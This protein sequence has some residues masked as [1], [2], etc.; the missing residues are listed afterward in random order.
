M[1]MTFVNLRGEPLAVTPGKAIKKVSAGFAESYHKGWVV[2]G[3]SPD[4]LAEARRQ[5]AVASA[6]AVK[7]GGPSHAPFD[8]VAY[9]RAAK[10]RKVRSK[11]YEI[12]EA[13]EACADLARRA[14]WKMVQSVAKAKGGQ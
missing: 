10:P 12:F 3:Y 11:P 1:S 13:A 2:V 14:G 6:A 7:S 9:M 5:H 4:Q 8:E